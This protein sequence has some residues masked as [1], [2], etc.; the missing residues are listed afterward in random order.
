MAM[1][2]DI[3]I[4]AL[5]KSPSGCFTLLKVLASVKTVA[6]RVRLLMLVAESGF[7]SVVQVRLLAL[8]LR[9]GFALAVH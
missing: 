9:P 4:R 8:V 2:A 7:A 5:S 6:A 1:C 3:L